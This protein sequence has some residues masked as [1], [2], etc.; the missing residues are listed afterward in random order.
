MTSEVVA[1]SSE[2]RRSLFGNPSEVVSIQS[3]LARSGEV[4]T[5]HVMNVEATDLWGRDA[6]HAFGMDMGPMYGASQVKVGHESTGV[7]K[8]KMPDNENQRCS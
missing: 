8:G 6:I 5:L 2:G 4:L 1:S 3:E 7:L